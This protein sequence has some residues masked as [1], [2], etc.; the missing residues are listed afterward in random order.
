MSE[1]IQ[2]QGLE[3]LNRLIET[4]QLQLIWLAPLVL[5]AVLLVMAVVLGVAI[6]TFS[7]QDRGG[8]LVLLKVLEIYGA[9]ITTLQAIQTTVAALKDA[10]QQSILR[11]EVNSGKMDQIITSS[12]TLVASNEAVVASVDALKR[13]I[14]NY[15]QLA[16]ESTTNFQDAITEQIEQVQQR[17]AEITAFIEDHPQMASVKDIIDATAQQVIAQLVEAGR[18]LPAKETEATT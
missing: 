15:S 10:Q 18:L 3:T 1:E 2:R 5:A 12:N 4:N 13:E 16:A 6:I 11:H 14:Q 8:N 7:R 17:Q 9:F